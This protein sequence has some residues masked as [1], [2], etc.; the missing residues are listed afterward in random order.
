MSIKINH[1]CERCGKVRVV[2]KA[3]IARGM[4]LVC[5]KCN[6]KVSA[7]KRQQALILAEKTGK[8]HYE[9]CR[10]CGNEFWFTLQQDGEYC[11]DTCQTK[12]KLSRLPM[13]DIVSMFLRRK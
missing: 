4:C 6:G 8:R 13:Q 11:S 5:R 12:G 10:Q 3:K 1:P 2:S 7:E 9:I